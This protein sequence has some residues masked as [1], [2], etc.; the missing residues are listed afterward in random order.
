M[1]FGAAF[2]VWFLWPAAGLVALLGAGLCGLTRLMAGGH[3][4]SDVLGAALVGYAM[5]RL[6]RPGSWRGGDRGPFLP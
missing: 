2:M 1:A 5:S 4:L 3:F 6:M